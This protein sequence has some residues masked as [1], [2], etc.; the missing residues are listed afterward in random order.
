[1]NASDILTKLKILNT[2]GI[3]ITNLNKKLPII[4]I[5]DDD[6]DEFQSTGMYNDTITNEYDRIEAYS[7]MRKKQQVNDQVLE[8]L[9][10]LIILAPKKYQTI[11]INIQLFFMETNILTEKQASAIIYQSRSQRKDIPEYFNL[12]K[13]IPSTD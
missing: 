10:E 8:F 13:I 1:M 4:G 9:H 11:L 12:V 7:H 6:D 3:E 2:T 5:I